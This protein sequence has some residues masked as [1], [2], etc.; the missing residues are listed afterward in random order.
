MVM[1]DLVANAIRDENGKVGT[2]LRIRDAEKIG[3]FDHKM[4]GNLCFVT[5]PRQ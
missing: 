2:R 4:V 3:E 1:G 5:V